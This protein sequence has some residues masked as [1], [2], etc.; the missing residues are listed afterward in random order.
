MTLNTVVL[1][2]LA[3]IENEAVRNEILKSYES[4]IQKLAPF[5]FFSTLDSLK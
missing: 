3:C 1:G 2:V 4:K 5:I